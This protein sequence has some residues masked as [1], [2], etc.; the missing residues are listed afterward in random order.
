MAARTH[1]LPDQS[2]RNGRNRR[3][4][5]GLP[6]GQKTSARR[7]DNLPWQYGRYAG[8]RCHCARHCA[9]ILGGRP[10]PRP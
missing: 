7:G 6:L 10:S 2:P 9:G 1:G 5:V 8:R 4:P 3:A